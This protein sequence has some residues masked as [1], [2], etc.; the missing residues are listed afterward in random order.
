MENA[1]VLKQK[2]VISHRLE[3]IGKDVDRRIEELSIDKL[4]ATEDTVSSLK[5]MRAELNKELTQYETDRKELKKAIADPYSQFEAIYKNEISDKYSDAI[6]KLGDKISIVETKIKDEKQEEVIR[7]F[8]ELC[9]A[10]GIDF[11]KFFNTGISVNLSTSLKQYKEKCNEFIERIKDDVNLIKT[12]EHEVE[13]MA[14]YKTCLNA[15]K[16]V[17]TVNER[18]ERER[19]EQIRKEQNEWNR[20]LAVFRDMA[21]V[22]HQTTNVISFNDDI[23]IAADR[24]R[25]MDKSEFEQV[26]VEFSERIKSTIKQ[27]NEQEVEK[28]QVAEPLQA[29]TVEKPE[30][31]PEVVKA[32]FRCFA[33]YPKLKALGQYMI[34]NGI[35]YENI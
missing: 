32:E 16:A 2:P 11:V 27:T 7:Y 13:I 26:S 14:E 1:I 6:K 31:E 12:Q 19:Q 20:R 28:P 35:K 23:Y 15:S 3:E 24:L 30:P 4:V 18:K 25:T 17:T 21:M 10:E 8:D 5:N 33:T 34:A 9:V 29:P 22:Y